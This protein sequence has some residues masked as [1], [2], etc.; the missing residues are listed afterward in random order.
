MNMD[1]VGATKQR[2]D[3]IRKERGYKMEDEYILQEGV[4]QNYETKVKSL[5]F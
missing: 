3:I 1:D 2:I 4:T 5:S